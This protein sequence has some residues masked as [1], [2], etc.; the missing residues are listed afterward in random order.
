MFRKRLEEKATFVDPSFY[1]FVSQDIAEIVDEINKAG[2]TV[3]LEKID[4]HIEATT[5]VKNDATAQ[6]QAIVKAEAPNLDMSKRDGPTQ[7]FYQTKGHPVKVKTKTGAP[8]VNSEAVDNF[9]A[10]GD[11]SAKYYQAASSATQALKFLNGIRRAYQDGKIYPQHKLNGASSGRFTTNLT[12]GWPKPYRDILVG[13]DQTEVIW[14]FDYANI[15]GAIQYF[16]AN[17]TGQIE[18]Y[19]AGTDMHSKLAEILGVERQVAKA[20]RHGVGYGMTPFGIAKKIGSTEEEAEEFIEKFWEQQP[21][22]RT[23]KQDII[24]TARKMGYV[25]TIG[26]FRRPTKDIND[27]EIYA[28]FIQGT[29]AD[30]CKEAMVRVDKYLKSTGYGRLKMS[31]HDSVVVSIQF[32]KQDEV[33]VQIKEIMETIHPKMQLRVSAEP[34]FS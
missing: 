15:D 10:D 34:G 20:I 19:T 31:M 9:I 29:S 8:S 22:I 25:A 1:L 7:W 11:E 12:G 17:E 4:E 5:N 14:S 3:S 16:L 32:D 13:D 24:L 18:D 21:K 2:L 6:F 33:V 23:L 28:T 26:D 27:D 30:I